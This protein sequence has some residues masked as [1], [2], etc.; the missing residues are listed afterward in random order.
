MLGTIQAHDI[1]NFILNKNRYYDI[2]EGRQ[3]LVKHHP[4]DNKK[5][6]T[7]K[8]KKYKEIDVFRDFYDRTCSRGYRYND[9]KKVCEP[10]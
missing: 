9:T 10:F 4:L 1:E 3:I 2:A 5:F 8:P 6:V 7:E